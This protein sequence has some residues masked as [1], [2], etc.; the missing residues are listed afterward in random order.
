MIFLL[1]ISTYSEYRFLMGLIGDATTLSKTNP[2][3]SLFKEHTYVLH[4]S[5]QDGREGSQERKNLNWIMN[6]NSNTELD[7]QSL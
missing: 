6:V 4:F 2:T 1:D 3:S 5:G 7:V